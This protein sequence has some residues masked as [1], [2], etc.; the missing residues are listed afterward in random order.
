MTTTDATSALWLQLRRQV[1]EDLT[2]FRRE[3]HK[4]VGEAITQV[5]TKIAEMD[6]ALFKISSAGQTVLDTIEKEKA[7][8][9]TKLYEIMAGASSEFQKHKEAIEKI[10]SEVNTVYAQV[11]SGAGGD[12]SRAVETLNGRIDELTRHVESIRTG[13]AGSYTP[14][15]QGR[16]DKLGG[17]IPWKQMTPNTFGNKEEVWREW[18]EEVR[19]YLDA[20][21]PGMKTL[22]IEIEKEKDASS[23][24]SQWAINKDPRLGAESIH[25]W[26]ALKQLTEDHSVARQVVTTVPGEDGYAA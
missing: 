12:A 25:M 21:K 8:T 7:D 9:T 22:L 16:D 23:V 5:Q 13:A 19:D 2:T 3:M 6:Q 26:R 20:V 11:S 1:A 14:G 15:G 4:E 24:D 17:F 18:V 10:H